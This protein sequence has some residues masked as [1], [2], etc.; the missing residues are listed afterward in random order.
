MIPSNIVKCGGS[1]LDWPELPTALAAWLDTI[2]GPV[3]IIV[4][5]GK[6]VD[7]LRA[8][9]EI[10]NTGEESSH[11]RA[12]RAM[13][14]TATVLCEKMAHTRPWKGVMPPWLSGTHSTACQRWVVQPSNWAEGLALS[15]MD[16]HLPR[17]WA[18][19]SDS[20]ALQMAHSWKCTRLFLLKSA[21][22]TSASDWGANAK[23]HYVDSVFPNLVRSIEKPP[24]I[25][26]I[27]L[28]NWP[29]DATTI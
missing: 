24:E 17:S 5:G 10:H 27:N 7:A 19:T 20:L 3:A 6:V 1:L 25:I 23:A 12:L 13:D 18:T 16:T 15:G 2:S 4:G 26:C 21:S 8:L 22:P 11:W 9:H 28:R 14:I 29:V